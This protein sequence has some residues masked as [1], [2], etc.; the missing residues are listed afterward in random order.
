MATHSS[1]LAWRIPGMAEPGGLPS[2]GSHRAG[3]DWSDLAAAAAADRYMGTSHRIK[4][5]CVCVCVCVCVFAVGDE[6][7][8]IQSIYQDTYGK[9]YTSWRHARHSHFTIWNNTGMCICIQH[10]A[11]GPDQHSKTRKKNERCTDWK[12]ETKTS[13]IHSHCEQC[14][15][16]PREKRSAQNTNQRALHSFWIPGSTLRVSSMLLVQQQTVKVTKYYTFF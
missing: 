7:F 11:R 14:T 9:S 15:E 6:D 8:G 16:T 4:R 3:H 12:G 13:I 1:V 10:C 5:G 2:T